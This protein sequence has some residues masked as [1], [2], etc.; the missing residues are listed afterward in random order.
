[1]EEMAGTQ[2]GSLC[3]HQAEMKGVKSFLAK[4]TKGQ[5]EN[6]GKDLQMWM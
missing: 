3:F 6:I 2:G 4:G 1:M 5:V